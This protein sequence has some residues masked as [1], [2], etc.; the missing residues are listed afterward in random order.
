M[1]F[2]TGSSVNS[3]FHSPFGLPKCAINIIFAPFFCKNLTVGTIAWILVSSVTF[4][5][6][7]KGTLTSTLTKALLP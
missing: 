1:C 3:G 2:A 6:A 7:S 5:S 4:F